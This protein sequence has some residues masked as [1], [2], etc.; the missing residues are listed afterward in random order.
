MKTFVT[1]NSK[2]HIL[3]YGQS[4]T[5]CIRLSKYIIYHPLEV[6]GRTL[7][8]NI[9]ALSTAK[10]MILTMKQLESLRLERGIMMLEKEKE[11]ENRVKL[12]T[13]V[14]DVDDK[15]EEILASDLKIWSL[16]CT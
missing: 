14:M 15:I 3:L 16:Y 13:K 6:L 8:L 1:W 5:E 11:K 10:G 2:R 4:L 9:C 12:L 7:S